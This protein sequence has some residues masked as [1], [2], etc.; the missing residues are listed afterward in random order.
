MGL[1]VVVFAVTKRGQLGYWLWLC[2]WSLK[3]VQSILFFAVRF[4]DTRH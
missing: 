1:A 3:G 2:L 4:S